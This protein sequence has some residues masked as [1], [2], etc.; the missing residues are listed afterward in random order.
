MKKAEEM[1]K[2]RKEREEQ[3]KQKQYRIFIL[4]KRKTIDTGNGRQRTA[5]GTS[6]FGVFLFRFSN[7]FYSNDAQFRKKCDKGNENKCNE[8]LILVDNGRIGRNSRKQ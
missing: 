4:V 8:S 5:I 6:A 3:S 1:N 2:A 7:F